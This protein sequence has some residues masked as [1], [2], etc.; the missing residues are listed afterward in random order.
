VCLSVPDA[1]VPLPLQRHLGL[2]MNDPR[3]LLL[4]VG[5]AE[6]RFDDLQW[7]L[8]PLV[9]SMGVGPEARLRSQQAFKVTWLAY[10]RGQQEW[11][12]CPGSRNA[13]DGLKASLT[14]TEC[15]LAPP[16]ALQV[17]KRA[18]PRSSAR[19]LNRALGGLVVGTSSDTIPGPAL[20]LVIHIAA[21]TPCG[22]PV[23]FHMAEAVCWRLSV[24]RVDC[25]V[26]RVRC[27]P[28]IIPTHCMH[29]LA[30]KLSTAA[31]KF[32]AQ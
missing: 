31:A 21:M 26:G 11:D 12:T 22:W 5:A 23:P 4:V 19:W 32:S 13:T 17:V 10:T 8:K 25:A 14:C 20:Q 3:N 27:R 6:K 16:I 15:E 2:A 1:V 18:P 28:N 9:P 30:L 24:R 29:R 7:T